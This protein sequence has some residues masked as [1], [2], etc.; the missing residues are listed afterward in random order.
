MNYHCKMVKPPT[1]AILLHYIFWGPFWLT[2]L[3]HCVQ[4]HRT[5]VKK[6][7]GMHNLHFTKKNCEWV[8]IIY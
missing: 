6:L 7:S 3:P 4:E 5:N 2:H 8:S 1:M